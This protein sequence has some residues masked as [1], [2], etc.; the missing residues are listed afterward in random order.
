M[1]DHDWIVVGVTVFI[2]LVF[3]VLINLAHPSILSLLGWRK[4][5]SLHKKKTQE[6]KAYKQTKML[7]EVKADRIFYYVFGGTPSVCFFIL[8][9]A[10]FIIREVDFVF[11]KLHVDQVDAPTLLDPDLTLSLIA[12]LVALIALLIM[13]SMYVTSRRLQDFKGYEDKVREKWG[14]PED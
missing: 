7:Y 3:T 5:R 12:L 8:S 1:N 4:A 10:F 6:W 13:V 9:V 14:L 11:A 2:T